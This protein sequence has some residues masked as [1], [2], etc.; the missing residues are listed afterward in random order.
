MMSWIHVHCTPDVDADMTHKENHH[1]CVFPL[2]NCNT[3]IGTPTGGLRKPHLPC[4]TAY[5]RVTFQEVPTRLPPRK[6][7]QHAATISLLDVMWSRFWFRS[8]IGRIGR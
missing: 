4:K 7:L 8:G 6:L 1:S 5:A 3:Q 2:R